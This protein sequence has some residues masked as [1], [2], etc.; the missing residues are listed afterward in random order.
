M[1]LDRAH[2][3]EVLS[4][5]YSYYEG[6]PPV[7]RIDARLNPLAG[8]L[9]GSQL[10]PDMRVLD[11]GCGDGTTLVRH[12]NRFREGVGIDNDRSHLDLASKAKDSAGVTNVEL[13]H[14]ELDDLPK[15]PWPEPFD[16]VFS[17]RGPI[18]YQTRGVQAALRVLRPGGLIFS[19]VIGDL[20]HQEVRE[21]FG[22]AAPLNQTIRTLDQVKVAMERSGVG[23]RVAA[24]IVSKRYYPDVYEWLK[25]QC[26]IWAWTGQP[27]PLPD[28]PR[29]ELFTRRHSDAAGG[30]E[31]THHVVWVGGVKLEDPPRYAEHEH[32]A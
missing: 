31:V 18:G 30:I 15:H 1:T 24:D 14:L 2:L 21:V 11:I 23:I 13:L 32:F 9:I 16:L 20:H 25:F 19:E 4:E 3:A 26:G 6:P 27:L 8:D 5:S 7:C 17:E 28:D 29:L 10:R 22:D 12:S